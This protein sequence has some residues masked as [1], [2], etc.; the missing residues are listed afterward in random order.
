MDMP[1]VRTIRLDR[2]ERGNALSPA[3]VDALRAQLAD[4]VADAAVHTVVFGG[5]GKHFC[6]GFDLSDLDA[7]DDAQLLARFVKVELLLDALWRASVQTVAIA[8]GRTWGA[9]ADLFAA[10]DRRI[11]LQGADFRFPGARFGLV[12]GS[13]RLAARV[14]CD[15]ARRLTCNGESRDAVGALQ[16]GL[17]TDLV[18]TPAEALTAIGMPCVDRVTL[19]TLREATRADHGAA[20]ADS[21]LARL[22]R[23]AERP[24][25]LDRIRD[26][27][28]TLR[29]PAKP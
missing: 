13:R 26:Y 28:R 18:E 22:V 3:L 1:G 17:A 15:A 5:E 8:Q 21:D 2:P 12:L 14:G 29:R 24:G 6:T 16:L 7:T 4:A 20:D 23:S 10:C 11:A 19:A 27:Q 25:L 9:G